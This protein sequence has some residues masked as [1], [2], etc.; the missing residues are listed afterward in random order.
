M[1]A[2]AVPLRHGKIRE[3]HPSILILQ[4]SAAPLANDRPGTS[5]DRALLLSRSGCRIDRPGPDGLQVRRDPPPGGRRSR[6]ARQ[7]GI[8]A[9]VTPPLDSR[10]SAL[11]P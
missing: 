7:A 1:A 11:A 6:P 2:V 3:D 5:H 4:T 10:L 8:D 9:L